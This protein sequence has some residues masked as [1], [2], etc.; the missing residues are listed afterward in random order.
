[1]IK[2]F[3]NHSSKVKDSSLF[4]IPGGPGLSSK[5]LKDLD[6]L[7]ECFNLVYMDFGGVGES[8]YSGRQTFEEITSH[9]SKSI[10][11]CKSKHNYILGHSFGGILAAN[12]F[13]NI[14]VDGLVCISTPFSKISLENANK[15][16]KKNMNPE[17]TSAHEE[18]I[19][20]QDDA[21]YAKWLSNYGKMYFVNPEGGKL[22]LQDKVSARYFKD[23]RSDASNKEYLLSKL[24]D[25]KKQKIF[26]CGDEDQLIS[27]ECYMN[28]SNLG[29]FDF[30]SIEKASHFVSF[31]QPLKLKTIIEEK[32]INN[33]GKSL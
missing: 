1:M 12:I 19:K 8:I 5:T 22:I 28:D 24:K 25:N 17:L 23:N 4:V 27:S 21:S 15:N 26:I 31:D 20:N 33:K 29:G 13:L 7:S 11:S 9:F 30:V 16:Y 2:L 18:W 10:E 6:L 32:L 3:T 14:N